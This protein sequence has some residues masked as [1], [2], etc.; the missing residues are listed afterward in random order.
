MSDSFYV[1]TDKSKLD[2]PLIH[3]FLSEESYWVP[4]ISMQK[5]ETTVANSLCFGVYGSK[6]QV[7][8]ARVITDYSSIA[9][10]ADVFILTPYRG[11]GLSKLLMGEILSHPKLQDLRKFLLATKDAHS[12]YAQFGFKP[13]AKTERL[14][15]RPG[16]LDEG[17]TNL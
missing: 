6:G 8:F 4:G 13:Y 5:V 7:G 15:E 1:S 17:F 2:L 3:R 11:Q 14:M 10:I 16:R 12:L 9:Y